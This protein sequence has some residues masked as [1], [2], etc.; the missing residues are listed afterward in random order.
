MNR[1][2]PLSIV[3]LCAG[4]ASLP[5]AAFAQE[6]LA[7]TIALCKLVK[8]D[9]DRLKC[10]DALSQPPVSAAALTPAQERGLK[11]KDSFR[12]C[13]NCPEMVVVP[14]GSFT[15]GSPASKNPHF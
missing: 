5:G 2:W 1:L 13:E 15:M 14:A 8:S 11:P 7:A 12:E 4:S 9:S 3:A 10:F 6:P